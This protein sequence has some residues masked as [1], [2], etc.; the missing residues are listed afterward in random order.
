MRPSR[1]LPPFLLLATAALAQADPFGSVVSGPFTG[2][3]LAAGVG[4]P[5]LRDGDLGRDRAWR[6]VDA[7]GTT[8]LLTYG[9]KGLVR[10]DRPDHSD[11]GSFPSLH[12]SAAFTVAAMQARFHPKEA[13]YWY[14]G[15]TLIGI[16]RVTERKHYAHDVLVGAALGYGVA[17]LELG[18]PHGIILRP[19]I[20][21]HGEKGLTLTGRF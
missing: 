13:I 9:L 19:L 11:H 16:A 4:L 15:A 7:L 2:L 12:A 18:L 10:E 21:A 6:T 14:G 8:G 3:Y 5:L 1:L 17:Q 20:G